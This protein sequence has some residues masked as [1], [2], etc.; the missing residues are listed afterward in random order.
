MIFMVEI[1]DEDARLVIWCVKMKHT[2]VRQIQGLTME[3]LKFHKFPL[4]FPFIN[5]SSR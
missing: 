2:N 4:N 1:E 5:M 3:A